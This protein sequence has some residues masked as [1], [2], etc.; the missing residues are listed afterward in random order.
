[1]T[2]NNKYDKI[3]LVLGAITLFLFATTPYILNLIEPAKPIGQVIGETAKDILEGFSGDKKNSGGENSL[4]Q[5]WR[6]IIT[7]FSF[8][9]FVTTI[10]LSRI[11]DSDESNKWMRKAGPILAVIGLGF[12]V[13]YF[14]LGIIATL[15]IGAL[16]IVLIFGME[17]L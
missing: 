5:T 6:Y 1:M 13:F 12:F 11:S 14:G 4:R 9:L 7:I 17:V 15:V 10:I 16:A 2:S 3:A 8:I